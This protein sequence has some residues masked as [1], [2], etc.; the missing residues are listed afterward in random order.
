MSDVVL[1]LTDT[2]SD[3]EYA[4][5]TTG[6]AM[7]EQMAPGR[8]RLRAVTDGADRITTKGGLTVVA[9]GR[10]NDVD[11]SRTA[12]LILPGAD[13]WTTGH[14]T[15]LE[16]S[17]R[18]LARGTVVAAICGATLGLARRGVLDRRPHTSNAPEYVQVPGYAGQDHYRH[19]RAVV[20]DNLITASAVFPV[21]FAAAVFRSTDMFPSEIIDAWHGLYTTGEQR[22]F[23]RLMADAG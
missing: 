18:L 5:V 23:D 1:Y 11:E 3:W 8:F 13:T 16:L 21:D 6:L 19:E 20:D 2:M 7:A 22:Y 9:D 4:Y 15:V 12:A 10:L 14:A 17:E